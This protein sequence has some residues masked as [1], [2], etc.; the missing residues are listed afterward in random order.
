M[1]ASAFLQF[2]LTGIT[3]GSA[4]ALVALGFTLIYNATGIINFAQGEFVVL[5]GLLFFTFVEVLHWPLVLALAAA[6]IIVALTAVIVE[7]LAIRPLMEHAVISRIIVTI[8]VSVILRGSAKLIWGVDAHSVRPFSGEASL[9]IGG[10]ALQ[11]Q[12]LWVMGLTTL[13]VIAVRLFF[14][15]TLLGKAMQACA[16]NAEAA[17]LVGVSVPRMVQASFALSAGISALAGAVLAP[18]TFA[19]YDAGIVLGVKGFCGAIIGGLGNGLGAVLGGILLGVLEN[20]GVGLA[21]TGFAGLQDA[22]A[23]LILLLV[24]FL[25]PQGLLL[26]QRTEGV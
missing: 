24:L 15:R 1:T 26:R 5:G 12:Y 10:A 23:F 8:G 19:S 16:I 6:V 2:L 9:M 20:L 25:R 17:R 22:F 4:Y 11:V 3:V 13:A 14:D 7:R 21:P 18:V